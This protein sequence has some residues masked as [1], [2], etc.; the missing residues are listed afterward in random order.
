MHLERKE[1][2]KMARKIITRKEKPSE[3]SLQFVFFVAILR[4]RWCIGKKNVYVDVYDLY[5]V[6][7]CPPCNF[8]EF[9]KQT[10]QKR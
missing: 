9:P 5:V 2:K 4:I 6:K 10:L 7:K 3:N 1:F 8:H